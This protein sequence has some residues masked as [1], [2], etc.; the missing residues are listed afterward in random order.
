MI[1]NHLAFNFSELKYPSKGEV[2]AVSATLPKFE[3]FGFPYV[4]ELEM[5]LEKGAS[6]EEVKK[7][8]DLFWWDN[9]L[10]NKI[11]K[12]RIS[13][14][15]SMANFE[16]GVLSDEFSMNVEINRILFEYYVENFYYYFFSVRDTILQ[17]IN[18]YFELGISEEGVNFASVLELN[19]SVTVDA[20]LQKFKKKVKFASNIRNSFTHRYPLTKKD[21]RSTI[22]GSGNDKRFLAGSGQSVA[23]AKIVDNM[24]SAVGALHALLTS[25]QSDITITGT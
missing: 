25:L 22:E 24:K 9:Y 17:V 5:I 11:G 14:I 2:S 10:S 6:F 18:L 4:K 12:L 23:P 15:I 16:R 3:K 1:S 21:F 20:A 7:A 19:S 8:G 13:F